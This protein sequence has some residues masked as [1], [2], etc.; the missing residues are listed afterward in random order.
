MLTKNPLGLAQ[1]FAPARLN[2]RMELV[3]EG[4]VLVC[5][6]LSATFFFWEGRTL[7]TRKRVAALFKDYSNAV[8]DVLAIGRDPRN[9]KLRK[10]Q[11]TSLCNMEGWLPKLGPHDDF[12][13]AYTGARDVDDA[14][15]YLFESVGCPDYRP[16]SLSYASFYAPL[17]W[18]EDRPREAFLNLVLQAGEQLQ[19]DHG[20]AGLGIV[21]PLGEFGSG[22][23][24]AAAAGLAARFR[25]LEFEIP[26][27]D[28]KPLTQQKKIRGINWL[29]ILSDSW[30]STLGGE[31]ELR[32]K[33]GP[34]IPVH[35]FQG[36]AVIQA[37]PHPR[38][39]DVNRNE[40]MTHYETV[41]KTLADIRIR[42]IPG[43]AHYHGFDDDRTEQWL[44]RFDT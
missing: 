3:E 26:F 1:E 40:P 15:P 38:F 36:G 8:G 16:N 35:E 10:L 32:K 29:T 22:K 21:L 28:R 11:G 9:G 14:S 44:A 30:I 41:A 27:R 17:S 13:P 37:G 12:E 33:L 25:G 23:S 39:G 42:A 7:Q 31:A 18:A 20:Y 43:L 34:D 2:D 19:P 4:R 5:V 24:A 6:A